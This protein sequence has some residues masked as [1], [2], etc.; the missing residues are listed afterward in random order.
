MENE[1]KRKSTPHKEAVQ[2]FCPVLQKNVVMLRHSSAHGDTFECIDHAKCDSAA[3]S[4][5]HYISCK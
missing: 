1:N 4:C 2:R 3:Q 5:R